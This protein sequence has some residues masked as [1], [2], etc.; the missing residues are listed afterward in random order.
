MCVC[1]CVHVFGLV[2]GC[3]RDE[4]SNSYVTERY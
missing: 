3:E 4:I 2:D 1:E